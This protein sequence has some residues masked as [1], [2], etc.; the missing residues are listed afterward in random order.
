[1]RTTLTEGVLVEALETPLSLGR[2]IHSYSI[3]SVMNK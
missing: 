3:Q 1:M 2:E